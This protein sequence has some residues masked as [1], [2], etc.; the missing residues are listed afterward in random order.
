MVIFMSSICKK[1]LT[2][3]R[4]CPRPGVVRRW[5][6]RPHQHRPIS[7]KLARHSHGNRVCLYPLVPDKVFDVRAGRH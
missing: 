2:L 6:K 3:M 7:Q 5:T 1:R 4:H